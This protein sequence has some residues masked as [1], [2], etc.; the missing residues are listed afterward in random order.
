VNNEKSNPFGYFKV[1][2]YDTFVLKEININWF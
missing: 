1:C 2:E